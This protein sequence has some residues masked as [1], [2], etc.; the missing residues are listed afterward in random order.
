MIDTLI[1]T[2]LAQATRPTE[3]EAVWKSAWQSLRDTYHHTTPLGWLT[4]L[5]AIIGGMVIGHVVRMV[6][7]TIARRE[8]RKGKEIRGTGFDAAAAPASLALITVGLAVG[9]SGVAMGD[10][11][12]YF[13]GRALMLLAITSVGWFGFNFIETLDLIIRRYALRGNGLG[14][15][16]APLVRKSL[17]LFLVIVLV[18]FTADTVF[19][20]D[21]SAWLA[22]LGI[23][24]LAVTL[25]AQDS[26]K[27]LFGSITVLFDKPFKVG[28]RIIFDGHEGSVIDVGFRS[29]KVSTLKGPVV[30][31]PNA[32]IVDGSVVNVSRRPNLLRIIDI[33]VTYDTPPEKLQLG[34][35]LL[36]EILAD[37]E[38][39]TG[40]D[41]EK[42]P[43]RV[44]F[45][46]YAAANLNIRVWYWWNAPADWWGYMAH[47]ERF[48]FKLLEAFN[49]AGIEFAFPT[50]TLYL[51]GDP[52]RPLGVG[53]ESRNA[54]GA[55]ATA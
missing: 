44:F 42:F 38:I 22:G 20:L 40:F 7:T 17:R 23:A 41:L 47:S 16:F 4:L 32:R 6:L 8:H 50:Q 37:P 12:R 43:P 49:N 46:G 35:H 27:N 13:A 15:Q 54:K 45:E 53:I 33:G 1:Q 55:S 28:D 19:D 5:L 26:I 18:L 48:N 30:T 2:L 29:T 51:A 10:E 31:I 25:A 39:A 36:R 21:I 34:L 3:N 52:N 9:L 14:G 24:G 11:I